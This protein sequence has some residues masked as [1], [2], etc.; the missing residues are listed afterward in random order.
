MNFGWEVEKS[1]RNR[2]RGECIIKGGI[3]VVIF[4]RVEDKRGCLNVVWKV[5]VENKRLK[6]YN[7]EDNY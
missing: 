5:W 3:L 6:M 2:G 7:G 4:L 1:D